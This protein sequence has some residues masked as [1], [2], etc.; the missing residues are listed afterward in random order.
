VAGSA[1]VVIAAPERAYWV[2]LL[3][4]AIGL[5]AL[6][7]ALGGTSNP[8]A[9]RTIEVLEYLALAA[10]IPLACW[11]GGLYGLVRGLSLP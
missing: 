11:V 10:V 2:C 4:I 1:M 5:C 6:G 8:L 9:H 7:S 3:A